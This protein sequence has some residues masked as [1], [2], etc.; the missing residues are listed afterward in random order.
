MN[1]CIPRVHAGDESARVPARVVGVLVGAALALAPLSARAQIPTFALDRLPMAGAPDDG[2]AV[3]RPEMADATRFYGQVG[4]G[5][6][7]DPL[8]TVNYVHDQD[9]A[10]RIASNL[11]PFQVMTYVDVG[12]EILGRI[13]LQV[14][15]PLVTYQGFHPPDVLLD[16]RAGTVAF[17]PSHVAAGDLRIEARGVVFRSASRAFKLGL[18]AAASVPTGSKFAFGGDQGAG[19]EFGLA[20][21]YD[22]KVVAVTLNTAYRL[23]PTVVV[24]E[25]VVSSEVDYAL[26][27]YVP[28][29]GGMFRV[30]LELFGGVGANPSKQPVNSVPP[31]AP[32]HSNAGNLDSAPLEWMLNG[33]VFFAHR[34]A[35]AGLGAGSRLDGGY[36]PDFR[37]VAVLGGA[38][39]VTEPASAR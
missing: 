18:S 20:V 16:G 25:L 19:G 36:A 33:K 28:L 14:S 30:G 2:V 32:S 34:H 37:A 23:R 13:G 10:E 31:A 9:V 1:R 29:H 24:N 5:L 12:A 8:R 21:E 27:A 6:S 15:F 22:P 35:Y 17:D 7:V 3:W 39:A 26:G 4:L 38:I 11:I